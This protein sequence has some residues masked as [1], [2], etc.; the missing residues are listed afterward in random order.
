MGCGS[1]SG[2]MVLSCWLKI[3]QRYLCCGSPA[4]PC[5]R[6]SGPLHKSVPGKFT[7]FSRVDFPLPLPRDSGTDSWSH[8]GA[9]HFTWVG[10]YDLKGR[11]WSLW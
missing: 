1:V 6:S 2:C 11:D 7:L 8:R 5:C 9:E 4:L 3:D 10:F